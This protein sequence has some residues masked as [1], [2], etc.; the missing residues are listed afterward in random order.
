MSHETQDKPEF[1]DLRKKA[2][3][4]LK[5]KRE[6]LT[7]QYGEGDIL[8]LVQEMEVSQIELEM[9]NEELRLEK[10]R[11]DVAVD[12][13]SDLYDE[14][15]DFSPAGYFTLNNNGLISDINNSATK[16]LGKE[17]SIILKSNFHHYVSSEHHAAFDTF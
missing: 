3:E 4:V 1:T 6:K 13:F 17:R 12:K 14:I 2:E 16:I 10:A 11:A 9:Q 15:Y 5:K 8:K 7:S